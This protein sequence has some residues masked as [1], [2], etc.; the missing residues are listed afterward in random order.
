MEIE[1]VHGPIT[2]RHAELVTSMR[3]SIFREYPYFYAGDLKTEAEYVEIYT[4]SPRSI[5]V[6]AK[7]GKKVIGLVTG[8]PLQDMD[9]DLTAPIKKA[10]LDL[11]PIYYL[12][13]ILLL[14]EFRGKGIGYQMYKAFEK[15]VRGQHCYTMI[16]IIRIDEKQN[17]AKKPKDYKSLQEFWTRLGF[18]EDLNLS[19]KVPY[20]E[21]D[22][23]DKTSHTFYYS[24]KKIDLDTN[25]Q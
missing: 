21:I 9:E 17:H 12:G 10:V 13:E 15:T 18:V 25:V 1:I 20:Q 7:E 5:F 22:H 19:L 2:S 4:K 23:A 24:L 3:M 8:I 14:K 16:A 6:L 11:Q